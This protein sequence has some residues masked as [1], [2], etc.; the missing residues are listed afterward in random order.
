MDESGR[1][2]SYLLCFAIVEPL[3]LGPLRKQLE[4]M[5]MRG[6]RELHFSHEKPP[7]RRII[8]DQIARL[9]ASVSIYRASSTPRTDEQARQSCLD[10]AVHDLR[11][12]NAALLI[13]DTRNERDQLDKATIRRVLKHHDRWDN[14][15]Y[16]HVSSE[17]EPLVWI[18]D[19]S[20]WCFGAGGDWRRR[21]APIISK[22]IDV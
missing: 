15:T 22:L 5:R 20:A 7:R 21:I 6:Q 13:M 16:R 10:R 2:G 11:D 4:S 9:P 12:L 14:F 3:Q 1:R 17:S 18:A 8:A 19:I